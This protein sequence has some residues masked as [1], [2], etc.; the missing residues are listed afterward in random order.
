MADNRSPGALAGATGAG[1]LRAA[2]F[3]PQHIAREAGGRHHGDAL[4]LRIARLRRLHGLR[5]AQAALV[6]ALAWGAPDG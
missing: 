4:A 5:A 3:G 2:A 6:A 1:C